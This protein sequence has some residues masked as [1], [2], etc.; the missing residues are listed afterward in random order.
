MSVQLDS[1]PGRDI[2]ERITER[3]VSDDIQDVLIEHI[4]ATVCGSLGC[5]KKESL[6]QATIDGFGTRVVCTNHLEVLLK[7]EVGL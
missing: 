2:T 7:R 5:Q 3:S 1:E 6:F 4:D